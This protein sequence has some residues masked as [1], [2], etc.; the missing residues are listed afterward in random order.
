MS[1][2]RNDNGQNVEMEVDPSGAGV[3]MDFAHRLVHEG[4][5]FEVYVEDLDLDNNEIVNVLGI[6]VEKSCHLVFDIEV[7]GGN[8]RFQGFEATVISANG[9]EVLE[10]PM[11]RIID[12]RS[13]T[14]FYAGPTITADG[15]KFI[16]KIA[17]GTAQGASKLGTVVREGVERILKPSTKYLFRMTGLAD[18]IQ[19]K[20]TVQY[21]E[22]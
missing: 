4:K 2:F 16:D 14:R 10:Q 18:N 22:V 7:V 8:V 3:V 11:N 12:G 1:C 6:T 5:M 13:V 20:V 21:Y 9:T 19:A 17:F 15:T